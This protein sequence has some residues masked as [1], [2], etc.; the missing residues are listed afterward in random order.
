MDSQLEKINIENIRI[1]P[2]APKKY[3]PK[4]IT[5]LLNSLKAIGQIQPIVV[6]K[7]DDFYALIDGQARYYASKELGL[8]SLLCKVIE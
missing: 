1:N 5:E 7:I 4:I 6:R 3:G 8:K 2:H